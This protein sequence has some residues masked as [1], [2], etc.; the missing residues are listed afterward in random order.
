M[1]IKRNISR[2][3]VFGTKHLGGMASRHLH[4]LQGIRRTQYLIG[5]LTNNDGVAKLMRIYIEATKLEVGTFEAFFFLLYYLHG[6]SLIS[7]SW[8]HNIW[9]FNDL[10]HSTITLSN[11]W[12]PHPQSTSNKAIISLVVSFTSTKRELIQINICRLFLQA[13]SISDICDTDGIHITQQAYDG[14]F[15]QKRTNIRSPNQHRPSKGGWL[16]WRRF[17]HSFSHGSRY[18]FTP[19]VKGMILPSSTITMNGT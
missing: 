1:G 5:H 18:I 2:R 13:I 12:L 19:I 11:Y 14:T 7:R 6:P 10:F 15:V 17:R 4:T 8:I 16:I 9:S 3:I